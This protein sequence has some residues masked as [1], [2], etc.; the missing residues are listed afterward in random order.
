MVRDKCQFIDREMAQLQRH[1]VDICWASE[2]VKEGLR[3]EIDAFEKAY[4]SQ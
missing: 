2:E 4:L 3:G 1:A